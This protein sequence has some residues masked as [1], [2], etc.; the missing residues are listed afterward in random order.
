MMMGQ[1]RK[2]DGVLLGTRGQ[3]GAMQ[4]LSVWVYNDSTCKTM[5]VDYDYDARMSAYDG[6]RASLV[7]FE[8]GGANAIRGEEKD[9]AFG[10]ALRMA[11]GDQGAKL[12][13]CFV[14]GKP[15]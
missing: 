6:T 13:V 12:A 8:R 4:S 15:R 2:L 14:N 11:C 1:H 3:S 10:E 5:N 7:A 9:G